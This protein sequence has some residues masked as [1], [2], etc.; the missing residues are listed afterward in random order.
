MLMI[1][2]KERSDSTLQAFLSAWELEAAMD[3]VRHES[4]ILHHV[5]KNS[6]IHGFIPAAHANQYGASL[7]T[8]TIF[9]VDRFEV[10]QCTNIYKITDYP[11]VI[12]YIPTTTVDEVL[13]AAPVI[14]LHKFMLRKFDHLQAFANTN[15]ELPA[16]VHILLHKS[17]KNNP[18]HLY[19]RLRF[20]FIFCRCCMPNTVS[21][22]P[23]LTTSLQLLQLWSVF[24]LT[25]NLYLNFPHDQVLR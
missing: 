16:L 6:V 1:H 21:K 11:F 7:R 2:R 19:T 17:T 18:L 4:S 13:T 22:V 9:K 24:S 8:G 14:N 23:L 12:R 15:L 20:F 25:R 10:G 5:H 3:F